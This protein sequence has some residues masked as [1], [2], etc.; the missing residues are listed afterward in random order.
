MN[1]CFRGYGLPGKPLHLEKKHVYS[2]G[3]ILVEK[4]DKASVFYPFA[5]NRDIFICEQ[6]EKRFSKSEDPLFEELEILFTR[7]CEWGCKTREEKEWKRAKKKE[8]SE[9]KKIQKEKER[10]EA[11]L[12]KQEAKSTKKKYIAAKHRR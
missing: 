4:N 1:V 2:N 11:K 12:K 9:R 8:E 7:I 10:K 3:K 5:A 6:D